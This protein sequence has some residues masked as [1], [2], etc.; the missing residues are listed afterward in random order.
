MGSLILLY[1]CFMLS[2]SADEYL[3]YRAMLKVCCMRMMD[4][5]SA[6]GTKSSSVCVNSLCIL[7][8][9]VAGVCVVLLISCNYILITR[10]YALMHLCYILY[11]AVQMKKL[12][13]SLVVNWNQW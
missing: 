9:S 7:A 10:L 5:P 12:S 3:H 6:T 11:S 2:L 4:I 13:L 8:D 1:I